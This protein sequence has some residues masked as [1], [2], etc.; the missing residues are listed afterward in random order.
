MA[1]NEGSTLTAEAG[2]VLGTETDAAETSIGRQEGSTKYRIVLGFAAAFV[3]D[4]KTGGR[5]RQT[6]ELYELDRV[7][8]VDPTLPA[9]PAPGGE[10][11]VMRPGGVMAASM[12][13]KPTASALGAKQ[14]HRFMTAS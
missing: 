6:S 5:S 7:S 11:A 4:L 3:V 9:R 1:G 12:L 10:R 14:M 13:P 8:I 2:G